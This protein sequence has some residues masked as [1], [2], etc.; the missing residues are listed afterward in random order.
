MYGRE[1]PTKLKKIIG[2][3]KVPILPLSEDTVVVDCGVGCGYFFWF[4]HSFFNNYIGIEASKENIESLKKKFEMTKA[5]NYKVLNYAC[6]S[7]DNKDLELKSVRGYN[8]LSK[9]FTANNNSLFYEV[10]EK[11]SNWN[12]PITE[13]DLIKEKVETISLEGIFSK[14]NLQKIDFLKVDIE[15]AEYDFLMGKD[16]SK[17]RFLSIEALVKFK[18]SRELLSFIKNN[19]FVQIFGNGKDFTF[20]NKNENTNSI[21]YVDFPTLY[22]SKLKN[23]FPFSSIDNESYLKKS[24]KELNF[25]KRFLRRFKQNSKP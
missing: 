2:N 4:Y 13:N 24:S 23:D 7:E 9:G 17:V 12:N 14:L 21:F 19:G 10:G 20:A 6:Y 3:Y 22:F 1:A 18:K 5:N 15:K 25:I 8:V 11:Q 16:L